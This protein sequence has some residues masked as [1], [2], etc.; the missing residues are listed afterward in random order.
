MIFAL[1]NKMQNVMGQW[2]VQMEV[3]KKA[4]V[5]RNSFLWIPVFHLQFTCFLYFHSLLGLFHLIEVAIAKIR[6]VTIDKLS[7]KLFLRNKN[8]GMDSV[9]LITALM[10]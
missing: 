4:A 9:V 6:I 8:S 2:I 3:M 10:N 1:G 7:L 5:S